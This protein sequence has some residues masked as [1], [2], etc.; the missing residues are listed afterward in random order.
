MRVQELHHPTGLVLVV[1][2]DKGEESVPRAV[3]APIRS[4]RWEPGTAGAA[5]AARVDL[6]QGHR[7]LHHEGVHERLR[8]VTA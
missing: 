4:N 5:S 7:G 3:A 1:V 8:E 2:C 6:S